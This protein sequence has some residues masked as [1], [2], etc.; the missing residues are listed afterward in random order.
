METLSDFFINPSHQTHRKY[1]ALRALCVENKC[2][3][4]VANKFGYSVHTVNAFK[5]DFSQL[6]KQKCLA[7]ELFFSIR[8]S[9]RPIDNK[10]SDA[11][12]KIIQMRK[13]NF[14]ILDIQTA[15]HADGYDLTHDYIYR[16]LKGDGFTRLPKRTLKEKQ[17]ITTKAIAAPMCQSINWC[18]DNDKRYSSERGV[19]ILAFLPILADLHVD[20]WIKSSC[21]PETKEL[22]NIA[23]V[24][25][26]LALKLSG[27]RRYTP[28]D[29]WAMDRGFGLFSG[30]N[31]LPKTTTLSTY[32]YR[33]DRE[34]NKKFLVAMNKE[35]LR[36]NML[37]KE[38][39]MDFTT[40]PHWGDASVLEN[41]WSG[42]RNKALKSVLA[43]LC[44]DQDTGIIAYSN[45][46]IKHKTQNN[47][48]IEF[49][50]F[51]KEQGESPK[52]LIFD[53]KFT[54]YQ[55]LENLDKDEVK[56]ITLRRRGKKLVEMTEQ[57]PESD[58]KTVLV[59]GNGRK[60]KKIKV[61]DSEIELSGIKT[62]FRQIIVTDNG[63]AKPSF[64]IMND[65][66][67][68]SAQLI[69]QYGKRWNVEKGISEQIEFFHLNSLSSSI[70][71]KVDFDLTMSIA[72]HNIY[73][74]IAQKINGFEKE[75]STSLNAKFFTNGG[76]FT[77]KEDKIIVELKKKRHLPSLTYA[78]KN[79]KSI[80]IPWLGDRK[81]CYEIET[82]S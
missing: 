47:F 51:W 78:L 15:L 48:V 10:K 4:E 2:A 45:A 5:K 39:N 43:A 60:K 72:A 19:G 30:L 32:S 49:V 16:V 75:V 36:R 81:L 1:E 38:I 21:Y 52:C 73:R 3:R 7:P 54:T 61:H 66:E 27:N 14:S 70:V 29:L 44:Q 62:K 74:I 28:D 13:N 79:Y 77:I 12:D 42:K 69:R 35:L 37:T 46:E 22:N 20:E 58:W 18:D 56:F 31:V 65:R 68:T 57:L 82:T 63:H 41:N 11:K 76:H 80:N 33:I 17:T 8:L 26:F 53:S 59:D 64:F 24:L 25:S 6:F 55:N 71:V 67:K 23:M 9:G 34:M 40:I 50:D